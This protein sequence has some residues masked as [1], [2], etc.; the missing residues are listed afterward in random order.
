M[1]WLDEVEYLANYECKCGEVHEF[2]VK[3]H[4][5]D[6]PLHCEKCDLPMK[7]TSFESINNFGTTVVLKEQNGRLYRE[8]RNAKGGYCHRTSEARKRYVETGE[9]KSFMSKSAMEHKK[10]MTRAEYRKFKYDHDRK[11]KVENIK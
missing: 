4:D 1:S 3:R 11:A 6:K 10:S 5:M 8:H 7:R 9:N 2:V